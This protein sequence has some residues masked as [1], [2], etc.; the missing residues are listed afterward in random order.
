MIRGMHTE[1]INHHDGSMGLPRSNPASVDP[2][3]QREGRP[4]G[5][6]GGPQGNL[7]APGTGDGNADQSKRQ[8]K[9]P[10]IPKAKTPAQEAKTVLW[11]D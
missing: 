1:H 4:G 6:S 7:G 3:F 5:G 2:S 10:K 11:F 9:P 8:P